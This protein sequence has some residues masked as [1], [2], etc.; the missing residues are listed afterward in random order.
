MDLAS[1]S[2]ASAVSAAYASASLASARAES[3]AAFVS[4][5]ARASSASHYSYASASSASARAQP[6]LPPSV[7]LK[8]RT[9]VFNDDPNHRFYICT[10]EA[11]LCIPFSTTLQT[12]N[13]SAPAGSAANSAL[14]DIPFSLLNATY[15][16]PSSA[17]T[18]WVNSFLQASPNQAGILVRYL[19]SAPSAFSPWEMRAVWS[20]A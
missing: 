10:A 2:S 6:T 14:K 17:L 20:T 7:I 5:A 3:S 18:V 15:G 11:L 19:I 1:A 16:S 12:V 4:S 8:A 13:A 9:A